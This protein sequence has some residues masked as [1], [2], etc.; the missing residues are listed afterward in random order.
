MWCLCF[1]CIGCVVCVYVCLF[2]RRSVSLA[3]VWENSEKLTRCVG[4][5]LCFLLG[6]SV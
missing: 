6:M 5:C 3:V 2:V 1:F 4:L